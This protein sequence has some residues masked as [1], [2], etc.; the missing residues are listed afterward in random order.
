MPGTCVE[1]VIYQAILE[2]SCTMDDSDSLR[3]IDREMAS[4]SNPV[5]LRKQ[6]NV[7]KEMKDWGPDQAGAHHPG[8]GVLYS[9][10]ARHEKK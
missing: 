5:S 8:S 1:A 9:C 4:V 10:L 2:H 6:R 7:A 3:N